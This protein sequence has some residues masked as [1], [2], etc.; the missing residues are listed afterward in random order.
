MGKS[1][2]LLCCR[3]FCCYKILDCL[4]AREMESIVA[5]DLCHI[6]RRDNLATVIHTTVEVVFRFHPLA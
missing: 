3:F 1:A 5:H 4:T 2:S 6:R